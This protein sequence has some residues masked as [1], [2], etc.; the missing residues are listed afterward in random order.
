[1]TLEAPLKRIPKDPS[2][3][4][5]SPTEFSP[6]PPPSPPKSRA[7]SVKKERFDF[8]QKIEASQRATS[9]SPKCHAYTNGIYKG[10]SPRNTS[11]KVSAFFGVSINNGIK[12]DGKVKVRSV[13]R[14]P[15]DGR[16]PQ[17]SLQDIDSDDDDYDHNFGRSHLAP[18]ESTDIK[19]N[20]YKSKEEV[21][22]DRYGN[23]H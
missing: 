8:S 11:K 20:Y 18:T 17:R 9:S 23:R 12:K 10:N 22:D 1:M 13:S 5:L 6:P 7:L 16:K 3:R 15:K 14:Q 2:A 4:S 19:P 21:L